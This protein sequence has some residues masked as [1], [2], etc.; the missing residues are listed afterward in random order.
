MTKSIPQKNIFYI[1]FTNLPLWILHFRLICVTFESFPATG[2][3]SP[4][5]K[6]NLINEWRIRL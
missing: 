2:Y 1:L 4:I 3:G 5:Q 6:K